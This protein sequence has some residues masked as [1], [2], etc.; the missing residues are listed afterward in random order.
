M[1][2]K[3]EINEQLKIIKIKHNHFSRSIRLA[4]CGVDDIVLTCPKRTSQKVIDQALA[5]WQGYIEDK[6]AELSK[7]ASLSPFGTESDYRIKKPHAKREI[8]ARLTELNVN[9]QFVFNKVAIRNPKTRWGSCSHSKTL[10]FSY[11]VA[12]LAPE[13]RDYVIIHELCHLK[14]FNHSPEF[15]TQV[16]NFLPNYKVLRRRLKNEDL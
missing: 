12:F 14:V 3:I 1:D 13:L 7:K 6:L 9:N 8:I 10:S 2:I 11:K 5:Q 15:W 4:V 16:S